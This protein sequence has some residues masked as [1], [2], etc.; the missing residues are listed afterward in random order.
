MDISVQRAELS[1]FGT[2]PLPNS[3][4]GSVDSI[5]SR[6]LLRR[7]LFGF[8]P[9]AFNMGIVLIYDNIITAVFICITYMYIIHIF[10]L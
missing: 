2:V 6:I 4:A 9:S 10:Y 7:P 1:F 5:Y 8:K 3:T